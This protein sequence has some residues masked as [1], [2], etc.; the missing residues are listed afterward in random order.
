MIPVIPVIPVVMVA[1]AAF[2]PA[3]AVVVVVPVVAVAV[4]RGR[5]P[6]CP[7]LLALFPL[8]GALLA[9]LL[10]V[11]PVLL[12]L[13]FLCCLVEDGFVGVD[14]LEVGIARSVATVRT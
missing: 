10:L 12:L 4:A 7:A 11:E 6:L 1:R 8:G 14:R 2:T 3:T 9:T 13:A 5:V